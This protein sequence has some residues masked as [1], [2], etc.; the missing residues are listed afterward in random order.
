MVGVQLPDLRPR[1][2]SL[3][4][5]RGSR[6]ALLACVLASWTIAAPPVALAADP[7]P[8]FL[9]E[10]ETP[11]SLPSGAADGVAPSGFAESTV[12]SGLANP[13][14]VQFSPDGR[15]FV[16]EKS[17]IIKVFSSLTATTPTVFADLRTNVYSNW[18]RGLLGMALAPTFPTDPSIYV[19]YTYDHILGDSI[20][21]P[22]WGTVGAT[23]DGCPSP[24][25]I[26]TAGCVV[27]GRLSKLT[28]N[29]N[30][31]TGNEQVLIEDWCQQF[32]SHSIG[33]VAFG[34]D[35]ALYAGGG[36]GA[37][38][39]GV[40]YGQL[41]A[42]YYPGGNPCHD[43][44]APAG[45]TPTP[46][47]A[48][49]GALRT[50]DIRTQSVAAPTG[51]S[52]SSLVLGA[53]PVG[54]WRL[55]DTGSVAV[56]SG[57]NALNGSYVGNPTRGLGG[58]LA[59]DANTAVRF[60]SSA[61]A[62]NV[63]DNALLDLGDAAFS[64]EFWFSLDAYTGLDQM[65]INRGSG[66]PNVNV[67]ETTRKLQ[68]SRGGF[69]PVVEGSTVIAANGAWHHVVVTRS[70][71]GNG[72]TKIYLDGVAETVTN[73]AASLAF[74]D[75]N[76]V[77]AFGRKTL[78]TSERVNGRMDE[79]SIYRRVLSAA[80]VADHY[81]AGIAGSGGG[82]TTD[83]TGLDG[84]IIRVD[85]ATG[86]ALPTNPNYASTDLNARRII[87]YGMRNPFRFAP[88]PG[89][90][91]L[92]VG[93]VG[94]NT[95][96]EIDRIAATGDATVENFGW[97][98]YEG[99]PRQSSYDAADLTLCESLYTGG[100]V[101]APV[102]AYSHS[103]KVV[104]G[105]S[106]PSGS[107][108]LSGMAFYPESGGSYPTSYRGALF[109]AD[110]S[111]NC[112][113]VMFK[114]ANGQPDPAS[115]QTFVAGAA[116]PVQLQ[117]GPGGD[118]FYAD[119]NGGTIRRIS[120][121]QAGQAP[122]AVINANP[123]SGAAPL[124]VSLSGAGS[125]DPEGGALTYAWDFTNDGT[126]DATG[127]S[128]S[129]TYQQAGTYTAK[130]TVTDPQSLTGSTTRLISVSVVQNAPPVPT[131]ATPASSTT[132]AVGTQISFSGSA[133]DPEDGQLAASRLSWT[134]TLYHCPSNCHTHPQQSWPGVSSGSFFAPDHEYPSYLELTLTATDSQN[135]SASTSVRLD[136]RTVQITMASAPA[137]LQMTIN[138]VTQTA[139]FTVSVIQGSNNSISAPTPQNLGGS[140]YAF[141]SW[142]DGLA[143]TH[144]F[145]AGTT[146]ATYTATYAPTGSSYSSLVLGAGPVGYWRLGDTGSVAVDSGPNALNG[147]YVGNPTRG[148][149]GALAGDANTAVRFA[150]SADAVNVPDNA[151]LDLG[152]AAFS[153]EFWFSLDAYTG[154]DQMLI[155]RGS[156][157]PNVNV[158]ET[159]R[160]LQLSRGGFGPVVE[161]STVIAANGAWHHVVVTRSGAGN[162]NTKIYLD[163]VA[164]TVTNIAA[165][166]AFADTNEV[167]AFGRKTLD[168][169]ERVNGRMDEIS[170]Y[171]RVLSAAEVAD[172][173]AAG[174][175]PAP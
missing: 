82:G 5:R 165:S 39:D 130:L 81:A 129:F 70:G 91:E 123:T 105:E 153:Y 150:S 51:S 46:P 56:D 7:T 149:G 73:I 13:S 168:T 14:A 79:I 8:R 3:P 133:T 30:V 17:G 161:G 109:F 58:A 111:R 40:D 60:A 166:L 64:Y 158:D 44:G 54:Y 119:L 85:P 117:I 94:W 33:T 71:A 159:T 61:D 157:A 31:W 84:T 21:A 98:C 172:H 9:A 156:G 83:P 175:A 115:V 96:E 113:W 162:G 169:S 128:T 66:A 101:T 142:S 77:L 103:A 23:T 116:G 120:Y 19:L 136:P 42:P 59:G 29:G 88:R 93:D 170:I 99:S 104:S 132:W 107:S 171:R 173:Y 127:V 16:A 102:F 6:L 145:T 163:G 139:P 95:S 74:A 121:T 4:A 97:P 12:F 35:G 124:Q 155:N 76:E 50:Q 89:T 55:G 63:P 38:F 68:L 110:Y 134:L 28:A 126:T 114:G 37:S 49:G 135:L 87:A 26:N 2:D 24:P 106:C 67:D 148:L 141:S 80:E 131:I 151:L 125:S 154:L 164:E 174:I 15:V 144:N 36:D 47:S 69:G 53:G 152:D 167:L 147:S 86:L 22:R 75:T 27:S 143:Q 90:N 122:T 72:N 25:G 78:D 18:D 146:N 32:P 65:L 160:K 138:S 34:S 45:Q 10:S 43:P 118:L 1:G 20:P 112:I 137:G 52:Y 48:E 57:P 92:W 100:G 41:G 62:V 108:S 140:F 11:S